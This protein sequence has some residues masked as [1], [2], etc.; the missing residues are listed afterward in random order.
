[1]QPLTN[2]TKGLE[3]LDPFLKQYGFV[4]DNFENDNG[5]GGQFTVATYINESK[6]FVIGYRYSIGELY[7][8]FKNF[9]VGHTF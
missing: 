6:K 7:Y 2:L 4:F 9:K 5:S 1:M 8:Q 3:I